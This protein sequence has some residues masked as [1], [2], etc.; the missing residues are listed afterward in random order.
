METVCSTCS[1]SSAE[2]ITPCVCVYNSAPNPDAEGQNAAIGF[3]PELAFPVKLASSIIRPHTLDDGSIG[4]IYIEAQ[5]QLLK[6][7]SLQS[8][9]EKSDDSTQSFQLEVYSTNGSKRHPAHYALGDYNGDGLL[10]LAVGDSRGS[11]IL[12][13]LQNEHGDFLEPSAFPSLANLSGIASG[14]FSEEKHDSLVV[15]SKDENL[16]GIS[17][18]NSSGRLS[19]PEAIDIEGKPLTLTTGNLDDDP[20]KR[21]SPHRQG[22]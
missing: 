20:G 2:A 18:I 6:M 9:E 5:T 22:R 14:R 16:L 4:L 13:Y 15:L 1:T 19:F 12:L 3:G 7:D 17:A 10:D 11:Q 21:N 8:K